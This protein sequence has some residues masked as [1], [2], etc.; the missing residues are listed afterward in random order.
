MAVTTLDTQPNALATVGHIARDIKLS[1]TVFAMPFALLGAFLAAGWSDRF[2][3]WGEFVLVVVC[4]VL[5]RTVAM[6][7][8]RW[9]DAGLDASNPRTAGRAVPGG[10]VSRRAMLGA[11][12]LTAFGFVAAAAGFWLFFDNAWP[13]LLSPIV[14]VVLGGY[15]FTKRWT[16]LCH[17]FLGFALAISPAAAAIAIAPGALANAMALWLLCAMVLC[18][19]AGFDVI[20]ALQD[21][22]HDRSQGLF[23]MPSRLGVGPALWVSRG[24][25]LLAIAALVG[26]VLVS[27]QLG[28]FFGVAVAVAAALLVVEHALVWG[29]KTNHLNMA[30]FTVN[31]VV[32]LLLGAAGI[33]DVVRSVG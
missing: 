19:V 13:V 28:V 1:H 6:T 10:K 21:V 30:F 12:L 17:L 22:E 25:H 27:D 24:L 2:P 8:N 33:V 15:S 9:A 18:W 7:V 4:M 32:S 29:S 11:A 16:W 14:L 26:C 5:A 3:R 20:Y 23:S 31:G